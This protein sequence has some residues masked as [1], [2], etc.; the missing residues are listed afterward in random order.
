MRDCAGEAAARRSALPSLVR[1]G[2]ILY[3][4]APKCADNRLGKAAYLHVVGA[5]EVLGGELL[6]QQHRR[7]LPNRLLHDPAALLHPA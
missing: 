3:N 6:A 1:G 5:T 7:V 4:I 2:E